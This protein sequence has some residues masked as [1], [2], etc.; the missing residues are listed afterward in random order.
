VRNVTL[1]LTLGSELQP[2]LADR[3]RI[4]QVLVNL[5]D[6][7]I[8]YSHPDGVVQVRVDQEEDWGLCV[9]VED[10]GI[11]IPEEDLPR[12]GER[13]YR[14]D[15][16]RARAEGG[17]GLGLAI[18]GALVEAHGGRLQLESELGQGTLATFTLPVA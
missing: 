3:D 2:V 17:S 9:T 10:Q 5:L 18:A 7:A 4:D 14:V 12:I 6:N 8:K 16:A 11:G 13:F 1:Q 15:R